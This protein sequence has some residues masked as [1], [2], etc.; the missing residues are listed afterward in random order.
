MTRLVHI[1]QPWLAWFGARREPPYGL[2]LP[3]INQA[4]G[5]F[6][7]EIWRAAGVVTPDTTTA[8][9]YWEHA[10]RVIARLWKIGL[11][12]GIL[13]IVSVVYWSKSA[14]ALDSGLRDIT[15]IASGLTLLLVLP[16]AVAST[17]MIRR[18]E[19]LLLRTG[20]LD[21]AG[22]LVSTRSPVSG[23]LLSLLGDVLGGDPA[24][25]FLTFFLAT[26]AAIAL[27]LAIKFLFGPWVAEYWLAKLVMLIA[28][29]I[30][31]RSK[32]DTWA[33]I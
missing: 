23:R 2:T 27:A 26:F 18:G 14:V 21:L 29:T 4:L 15:A 32:I 9:H 20:P 8:G 17:A 3:Q 7:L 24:R 13:G 16:L 19:R 22:H 28:F 11:C 10:G 25:K 12:A 6:S 31:I 5:R 1:D 33:A 30:E